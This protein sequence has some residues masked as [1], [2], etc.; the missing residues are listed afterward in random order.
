MSQIPRDP[1][2]D[3]TLAIVREGYEFIWNRCRRLDTDLFV[4]RVMGK[5][6][7]CI[8]GVEAAQLFYDEQ[9][10]QRKRAIPRRV[11]TSLFGKEAV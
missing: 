6:A 10:L 2:F 8:H 4:T 3:S 9:K 7:V 1:S 11:V 5:R